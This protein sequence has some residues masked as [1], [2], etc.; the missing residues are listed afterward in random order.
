MNVI[1]IVPLFAILGG[2]VS[3]PHH[4]PVTHN[5][6]MNKMHTSWYASGHRTANGERFKPMGLTA[7]HK[8]LRFGVRLKLTN[9]D[10]NKSVVV[11]INDRGPFIKGRQLDVSKGAALRLGMLA[12]GTKTLQVERLN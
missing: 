12:S 8:N 11:R 10:N 1:K 5:K 2:C 4:K 3:Q 6:I 7:A 9:P